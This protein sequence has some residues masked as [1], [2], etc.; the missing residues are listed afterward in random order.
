MSNVSDSET[1]GRSPTYIFLVAFVA[2]IGGFSASERDVVEWI[3]YNA[4]TQVFAKSLPMVYVRTLTKALDMVMDG[5]E[6]R[7]VTGELCISPRK[8]FS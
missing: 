8:R 2:A 3:T 7:N 5:N 1:S 6:R 4:R